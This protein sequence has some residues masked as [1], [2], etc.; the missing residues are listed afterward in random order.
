MDNMDIMNIGMDMGA[1]DK[2]IDFIYE[3]NGLTIEFYNGKDDS[4]EP[5]KIGDSIVYNDSDKD[6]CLKLQQ[7][8]DSFIKSGKEIVADN[9]SSTASDNSKKV[10][11][12]GAD[13]EVEDDD[14]A[15]SADT[16]LA[17]LADAPS[18]EPSATSAYIPSAAPSVASASAAAAEPTA[19]LVENTQPDLTQQ[20]K[21]NVETA[22]QVH[23]QVVPKP[24]AGGGGGRRKNKSSK[25]TVKSKDYLII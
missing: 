8:F 6:T 22:I 10:E 21:D 7:Q 11:R 1:T 2:Y 3:G 5:K 24:A 14:A 15:A 23:E 16:P 4:G 12:V 25:R 19:K 18:A 9:N 13:D 17:E 20:I